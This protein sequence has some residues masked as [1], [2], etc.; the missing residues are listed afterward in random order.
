M[1][2]NTYN[3]DPVGGLVLMGFIGH[4]LETTIAHGRSYKG[5]TQGSLSIADVHPDDVQILLD[6]GLWRKASEIKPVPVF[7]PRYEN[8]RKRNTQ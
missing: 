4:G 8:E 1:T 6:S 7:V 2:T 5:D 3:G